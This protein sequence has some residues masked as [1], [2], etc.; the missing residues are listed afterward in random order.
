M[1]SNIRKNKLD[2]IL[3][4]VTSFQRFFTP[5]LANGFPQEFEWKQVLSSLLDFS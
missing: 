3:I 2:I 1:L 4:I 5:A